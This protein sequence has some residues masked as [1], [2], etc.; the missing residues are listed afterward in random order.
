MPLTYLELENF[1]SYAGIQRIGPFKNF[2]SVIGPNGSGKSNLMDAMSFVLG[3]QSRDLRSSQMRDLIFRPPDSLEEEGND[4]DNDEDEVYSNR[5]SGK[6]GPRKSKVK[7][8]EPSL[9]KSPTSNL[10]ASATLIYQD[11]KDP[12]RETRFTRSISERG[13]GEYKVDGTVVN[14]A[15]Y[16][17]RLGD[18]GVLLKARNFLVFQGDVEAIA[19]KSDKQRTEMFEN[20]SG[21]SEFKNDYEEALKAKD[22]CES[23]ATHSYEKQK[24][25]KAERRRLKEQKEEA[26]RFQAML[27]E[28]RVLQTDFYLWQ[29]F[30]VRADMNDKEEAVLA[31]REELM[32]ATTKEE[33]KGKFL[34]EAKKEASK[35]RRSTTSLEKR[36]VELVAEADKLQPSVIKSAE[37]IK[38]LKKKK[39]ADEKALAKIR[40]E[41][42]S[43]NSILEKIEKEIVEYTETE[44]LLGEE[45][46]EAKK[47]KASEEQVVLTEEQ[48]AEYETIREAAAVASAKPR[49]MLA[50]HNR[51]LE[52]ARARALNTSDDLKEIKARRA[53]A[54]QNEKELVE[55]K[56]KLVKS[57]KQTD[58]DLKAAEVELKQVQ[59]SAR[60]MQAKHEAI[61]GELEGINAKLR[62]A[63]DERRKNKDE[64]RLLEAIS[65]LKRHF[66]GVMGRLVDLCQPTQRRYNLAVT[67][68][69]GKDMDA[70]VVDTKQTAMECIQ[71]LR[72]NQIGTLTFLPLDTLQIPSPA[73]TERIRAM[74]EQDG[75]YRLA[76]DVITSEDTIKKAVMYA[77]GNTIVC[78]DLDSA[79]QLCFSSARGG[80]NRFGGQESRLKAVTIGGAVISKAGTMTGGATKDTKSRSGVWDER[81]L[82]KLRDKKDELETER[83]KLDAADISGS[84]LEN[85]RSSREGHNPRIEELR[86]KVGNLRNRASYSKSD[87]DYTKTKLVEQ[88]RLISS[89]SKQVVELEKRLNDAETLINETNTKV[90]M[91]IQSVRD[92]E[93]QHYKPFR[94]K[95]GLKDF[96]AYGEAIGKARENYLKKRR[97]IREHLEKLKAK[98]K[99]EDERDFSE[100]IASK[101]EMVKQRSEKLKEAK[102]LESNI[103]KDVD[104]AKAKLAGVE[105]ELETAQ[106]IEK[107]QEDKVK[108]SQN[109]YKEAQVE[110]TR[111]NKTINT[112][113]SSLER[114][115]AKLNEILQK[116]RV[117]QADLP[118]LNESDDL[119]TDKIER[120]KRQKLNEENATQESS[121]PL[122]TQETLISTHFSQPDDSRVVKDRNEV[123]KID[124]DKLRPE[125]KERLNEREEKRAHKD[126]E[127]K[128]SKISTQIEQM[129]PNMR[130]GEAFDSATERLQESK[131]DFDKAKEN[132]RNATARFLELKNSRAKRF[133]DAF[134][135]IDQALKTIYKDMTKSSKHPLGGNAYLSLDDSEEPFTGGIKFNAMPPMKRFRD[136]EQLSG[137]EKTVAALALLFAIHSYR[138]APFFVMDEVDAALDNVNVLKVCNYIRQRSDDFQCIVIS[139][140]DMFYERSQSLVGICRDVDTNSSKTLTLDLNRFDTN[141][142]EEKAQMQ[143]MLANVEGHQA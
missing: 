50:T 143:E 19:S 133:N 123:E 112:E 47:Q 59:Q 132:S 134:N 22:E 36:R 49:Q 116:S 131:T 37:E 6:K 56:D 109:E 100:A 115:R 117:E 44:R 88:K 68:A 94:E 72:N 102:N 86:N 67:V 62:E 53:E 125:L 21:S 80:S 140:K 38:N 54:I 77:V 27:E 20:I 91:A 13:V 75:R 98:K 65:T 12:T 45:Y 26:D 66:P 127:S 61:D 7:G 74:L 142:D 141:D 32:Q 105:S 2:T 78:D 11:P 90:E 130:A 35:A 126:F 82:N 5:I 18:I 14:F 138:P 87:L 43:H 139:L 69:G 28:K 118:L 128:I 48:E 39:Q 111:L 15:S 30:H 9:T 106:E 136:M 63:R 29:M 120:N 81:E 96:N 17:A 34:K 104:A 52:T 97:S 95:T 73:S 57:M 70:L 92:A 71:Y 110:Q 101:Q 64:T 58:A 8:R 60:D 114:L 93:E 16:E 121:Y 84:S 137:G 83:A 3:V 10:K 129:A 113:E 33:E 55:R 23:A 41:A 108:N 76:C 51:K 119:S 135:H 25:C 89:T 4:K 103:M 40:T 42:D 24:G 107:S 99:Y 1:K 85:R 79:R 31:I 124:F 46:D 122:A